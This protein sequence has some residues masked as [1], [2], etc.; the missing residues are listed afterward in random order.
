[1]RPS[2][3]PAASSGASVARKKRPTGTTVSYKDTLASTTRFTI[4]QKQ[5]GVRSGK[6]CVKPPRQHKPGSKSCTRT[7]ALGSFNHSDKAGANSL[8]FTG[9]VKRHALKPGAY[10]LTASPRA[11]GKTGKPVT[12]RFHLIP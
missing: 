6:H 5:S 10:T 9:R 7:V 3:F 8:H 11:S 4:S 12:V 1:L 2:S